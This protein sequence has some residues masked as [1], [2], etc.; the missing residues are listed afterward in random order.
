[1]SVF[2]SFSLFFYYYLITFF[3]P[4]C[5]F[6]SSFCYAANTI[7]L[8]GHTNTRACM[9]VICIYA[10]VFFFAS[11]LLAFYYYYY[12]YYNY[13]PSIQAPHT[14]FTDVAAVVRTLLFSFI[15]ASSRPSRM[16]L[17][18]NVGISSVPMTD[19]YIYMYTVGAIYISRII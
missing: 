5:S 11:P 13:D 9:C 1:M 16:T 4:P 17:L 12:Y 19:D 8:C 2:G 7:T 14:R 18:L 15:Y 10:S 6:S 3:S